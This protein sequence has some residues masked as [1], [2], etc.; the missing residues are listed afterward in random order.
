MEP[1]TPTPELPGESEESRERI[2]QA[3]IHI[4]GKH[5][6]VQSAQVDG[7]TVITTGKWLKVAAVRDEE[8]IEG[9]TVADPESFIQQLKRCGL[10]ADLFTF[11]QRVPNVAP[12]R[13]YH[14]EWGNAA[15]IPISTYSH[16][17]KERI[18]Y[19]IRKGV[20]RA[21][22]IGVIVEVADFDD[23][24]VNGICHIY[25]ETPIRQ[26]KSFWHYQKDFV[27]VKHALDTYLDRSVFLAARYQSEL[28]GF[29]KITFLD[30][31]GVI[32]QILSARKHFDKRP[33]NALIA[34]AVELCESWGKSHFIYGDFVYF[35]PDSTLTEFKKRSGFEPI[36]LPRYYIPLTL[37]GKLALQCGF[38]RELARQ[39]PRPLFKRLLDI[40]T[41]WYKRKLKATELS[42]S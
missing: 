13:K 29:M 39:I 4:K 41:A 11:G 10:K 31:T 23:Q 21:K 40:R 16:W 5:F 27:S 6:L 33:N 15:A 36:A 2:G 17:W 18:E 20:N 1:V 38:H 34:K 42:S 35:D 25:N 26:G 9:D 19:S 22:K 24:L 8:L 28:I 32:T 12:K 30:G 14:I 37:K 3:E 7:K